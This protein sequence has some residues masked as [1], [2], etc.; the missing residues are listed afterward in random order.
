MLYSSGYSVVRGLGI[1]PLECVFVVY[2]SAVPASNK[3]STPSP[4]V[5]A[6]LLLLLLLLSQVQAAAGCGAAAAAA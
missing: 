1:L 4:A 6:L 2:V 3:H 5:A